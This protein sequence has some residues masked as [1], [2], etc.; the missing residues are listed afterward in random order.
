M[1]RIKLPFISLPH[2]FL[3]LLKANFSITPTP[4]SIIEV[5]KENKALYKIFEMSL[6]EFSDGHNLEKAIKVLGWSNFKER[7]ASIFLHKEIY[8]D[9]S[10]KT[11]MHLIEEIKVFE[12]RFRDHSVTS[13]SRLFLLAF[14]LKL[15][16]MELL[17][18]EDTAHKELQFG[19]EIDSIL[20]L[21]QGRSEKID[22]LLLI[23]F[24]LNSFLG[25]TELSNYLKKGLSFEQIYKFVSP[26]DQL[27]MGQNL[28]AYG[29]SIKETDFFLFE[30]V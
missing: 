21:S 11:H 9:Y 22:W 17:L 7:I 14:Y 27:I 13:F 12:T 28:L 23:I 16:N 30:K 24:H 26:S 5:I 4:A 19:S 6:T 18:H 3:I 2:E 10:F 20:N 25:H 8:G 15:A 29:A 1:S